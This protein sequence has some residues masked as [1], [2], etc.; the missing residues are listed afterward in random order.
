MKYF[1]Y[2]S[3]FILLL[4][5]CKAQATP[6]ASDSLRKVLEAYMHSTVPPDTQVILDLHLALGTSLVDIKE[7]DSALSVFFQAL[8]YSKDPISFTRIHY[9]LAYCH[10]LI[11]KYPEAIK[12][13]KMALNGVSKEVPLGFHAQVLHQLAQLH[14]N[15]G[16][17]AK[18]L[19]FEF[20]GL[21]LA[22]Q[23]QDS[24]AMAKAYSGLARIYYYAEQ[25][26]KA[27]EYDL[28]AFPIKLASGKPQDQYR[29]YVDIASSYRDVGQLDSTL[30]FAK[31]AHQRAKSIEFTHGEAFS[32]LIIGDVYKQKDSLDLALA[33]METSRKNFRELGRLW[34][35]AQTLAALGEV[36]SLQSQILPAIDTLQTA[37]HLADSLRYNSLRIDLSK[38]LADLYRE[39]GKI[40]KALQ[41]DS[42]HK[43]L[44]ARFQKEEK[45]SLN[46]LELQLQMAELEA[47]FLQ[48]Q[49]LNELVL[50]KKEQALKVRRLYIILLSLGSLLLICLL[51]FV[52][53]RYRLFKNR[54]QV[55][56]RNQEEKEWESHWQQSIQKDWQSLADK[57]YQEIHA[58]IQA[59]GNGLL[60]SS[61]FQSPPFQGELS[62]IDGYLL[63]LKSYI[64]AGFSDDTSELISF[65][66]LID[67]SLLLL[68]AQQRQHMYLV[69][70][71]LPPLRGNRKK[72]IL[73]IHQLL[74]FFLDDK[75]EEWVEIH[76]RG[77]FTKDPGTYEVDYE[78]GFE[79]MGKIHP[80]SGSWH[81]EV[82]RKIVHLYQGR[83]W[84]EEL[85]EEEVKVSFT[86]PLHRVGVDIPA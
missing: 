46:I 32:Y 86:L 40:L 63:Q 68:N 83:L 49:A 30:K 81:L 56:R 39:N 70:H 10:Q 50:L 75:K 25:H 45:D 29:A 35:I 16:K 12:H 37:L 80:Q 28:Q 11:D 2:T 55:L 60:K 71:D 51:A 23:A 9:E 73:L 53:A 24:L 57:L 76:I 18:A 1:T 78:F 77:N 8:P 33:Y 19:T 6:Q 48:E 21:H 74:L 59:L 72:M 47:E 3:I 79:G 44:K 64:Q 42:L 36:L 43:R 62:E 67:E 38:E 54:N 85:S 7:F 31:L 52:H 27:L 58:R 20:R 69:Q 65:K 5:F 14:V 82:C 22:R 13:S 26:P 84:V 4:F 34:P 61:S 41:Y 66:T 17:L 15:N